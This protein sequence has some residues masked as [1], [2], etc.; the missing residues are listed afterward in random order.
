[1]LHCRRVHHRHVAELACEIICR[2]SEVPTL[3]WGTDLSASGMFVETDEPLETGEPLVVCFQP[4][5]GWRLPELMLFAEVARRCRGRRRNDLVGGGVGL[6]L[7]DLRPTERFALARWLAPRPAR[8]PVLRL[9]RPR[10]RTVECYDP[11]RRVL[12]L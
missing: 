1:M 7:L 10:P 6:R 2:T 5:V 11:R 9:A 4:A 3:G 8:R 12:P